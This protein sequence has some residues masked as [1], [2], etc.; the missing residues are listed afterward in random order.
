MRTLR[1]RLGLLLF[2]VAVASSAGDALLKY[3]P[4]GAGYLISVDLEASGILKAIPDRKEAF[5]EQG[6]ALLPEECS[7]LLVVG[8]GENLRGMLVETSLP[9]KFH[10]ERLQTI[11]ER[12]SI[13]KEGDRTLY[14]VLSSDSTRP[15]IVLTYL[16]P[17]VFL[18]TQKQ[19]LTPFLS[20]L[21]A[22]EKER[23]A[24][25]P[26]PKGRP[27]FWIF[28]RV[29]SS[30]G[31][32]KEEDGLL[33]QVFNGGKTLFLERNLDEDGTGWHMNGSALFVDAESAQRT[34]ALLPA[35]LQLGMSPLFADDQV[36]W[37]DLVKQMPIVREKDRVILTWN[38]PGSLAERFNALVEFQKKKRI[39][40]PE[41]LPADAGNAPDGT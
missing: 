11:G 35:F 40:P 20:D 21:A 32:E 6:A 34:A 24:P 27:L 19:D 3:V 33:S 36:L 29:G 5:E 9:E 38:V 4:S 25:F 17:T 13:S 18:V 23:L 28:Y 12:F 14:C 16:D 8:D 1:F 2:S 30:D 22:P 31:G 26:I 37:F 7:H 15:P 41:Q 10:A 39:V